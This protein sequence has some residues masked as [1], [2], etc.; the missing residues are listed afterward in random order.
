MW[1]LL[2]FLTW[3]SGVLAAFGLVKGLAM[4]EDGEKEIDYND[5]VFWFL[6]SSWYAFGKTL[7]VLFAEIAKDLRQKNNKQ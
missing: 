5:G 6:C 3:L 4:T 1:F 7:G 2:I